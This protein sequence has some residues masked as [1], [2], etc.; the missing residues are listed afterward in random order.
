MRNG[1]SEVWS[2][3]RHRAA[4]RTDPL[5]PSR[6]NDSDQLPAF[7]ALSISAF[8]TL[9]ILSGVIGPTSL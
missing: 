5:G 3:A 1:A 2:G 8:I 9:S 4:L 7:S 6:N